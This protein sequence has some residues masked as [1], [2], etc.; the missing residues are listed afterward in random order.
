MPPPVAKKAPA[1]KALDRAALLSLLSSEAGPPPIIALA[2]DEDLLID[3]LAAAVAAELGKAGH[4]N[5]QTLYASEKSLAEAL[6]LARTASL[7]DPRQLVHVRRAH[8][9]AQR[10]T[11][12]NPHGLTG[13]DAE[14]GKSR[15]DPIGDLE[16]YIARP[17]THTTLILS[18]EATPASTRLGKLMRQAPAYVEV[19]FP[20]EW[21]NDTKRFSRRRHYE[22]WAKDEARRLGLSLRP[23]ATTLLVERAGTNLYQMRALMEIVALGAVDN[24]TTIDRAGLE[25]LLPVLTDAVVEDA[26]D[27][28]LSRS[29]DAL[30]GPLERLLAEDD[31]T[32]RFMMRLEAR[33]RDL[34]LFKSAIDAGLSG[35]EAAKALA[36]PPGKTRLQKAEEQGKR[37]SGAEIARAVGLVHDTSIAIRTEKGEYRAA[38]VTDTLLRLTARATATS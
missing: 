8:L 4:F 36:W 9:Y 1:P 14:G 34:A 19:D 24:K 33:I 6:M 5:H 30:F 26:V 7:F 25:R 3:E 29:A 16:R 37:W 21:D 38:R 32:F 13:G 15:A 35:E 20:E 12:Q 10:K 31:T 22:T 17:S 18:G 11:P 27:A 28:A 23:D 2:G